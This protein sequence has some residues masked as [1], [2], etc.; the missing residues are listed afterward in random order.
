MLLYNGEV[1]PSLGLL[2][3]CT[4]YAPRCKRLGAFHVL[5]YALIYADQKKH[6]MFECSAPAVH[7]G[8][9]W[10]HLSLSQSIG[11]QSVGQKKETKKNISQICSP[12]LKCEGWLVVYWTPLVYSITIHSAVYSWHN[13]LPCF[14]PLGDMLTFKSF[15]CH[16]FYGRLCPHLG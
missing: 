4:N 14:T 16:N 6:W 10:F 13:A 3:M 1:C 12:P 5:F 7:T 8:A 11:Q 2:S 9:G 15:H